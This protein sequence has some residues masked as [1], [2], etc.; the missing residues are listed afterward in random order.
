V[1][2]EDIQLVDNEGGSIWR[3]WDYV[4]E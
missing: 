2:Y 4:W 3:Q 1:N